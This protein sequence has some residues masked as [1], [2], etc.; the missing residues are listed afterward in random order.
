VAALWAV[1]F[2][3]PA[4]AVSLEETK[5]QVRTMRQAAEE[6]RASNPE[7]AEK[8]DRIAALKDEKISMKEHR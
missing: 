7:L 8:L 5:E 3:R 1:C 2:C 6:L 4:F